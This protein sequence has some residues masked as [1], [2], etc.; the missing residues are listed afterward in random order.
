MPPYNGETYFG[1]AA[2]CPGMFSH[3]HSCSSFICLSYIVIDEFMKKSILQII[4]KIL[5]II[6][7]V[8]SMSSTGMICLI[9]I[10]YLKY[11]KKSKWYVALLLVTP[12][13]V[14]LTYLHADTLTNRSEGS[15]EVSISIRKEYFI[16]GLQTTSVI[17]QTFG[18]ATNVIAQLSEKASAADAFYPSL[19][20]NLGVF[21]F[22]L[23]ILA[24][25]IVSFIALKKRDML[26]VNILVLYS[27]FSFSIV[28]TEVF[29]F[30]L[31]FA[32]FISYMTSIKY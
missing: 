9:T 16:E 11:I 26:M 13:L 2:R 6:G 32:L 23:M 25:I 28:V 22:L 10:M 4:G 3:A 18:Y 7:V 17:S 8:L 19:L 30:N 31:F 24:I 15:S 12:V 5:A 29:P 14:I 27:L 20:I 1:L 21:A